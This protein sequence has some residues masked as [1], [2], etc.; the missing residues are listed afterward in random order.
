MPTPNNKEK[1]RGEISATLKHIQGDFLVVWKKLD[2]QAAEIVGLKLDMK[3]MKVKDHLYS[4]GISLVVAIIVS[5]VI[6]IIVAIALK[7][8]NIV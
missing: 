8:L 4:G 3:G 5:S 7:L 1:W 6:T 2:E